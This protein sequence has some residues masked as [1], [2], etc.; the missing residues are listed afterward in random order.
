MRF[1]LNDVL[2]SIASPSTCNRRCR[3][4]L[5]LCPG[6]RSIARLGF[7]LDPLLE[8]L[9]GSKA[10]RLSA[11]TSRLQRIR[12]RT[13]SF[14][15]LR[16]GALTSPRRANS[17]E[18]ENGSAFIRRIAVKSFS[19]VLAFISGTMVWPIAIA[20]A[21]SIGGSSAFAEIVPGATCPPDFTCF[22]PE[23][24]DG[25]CRLPRL[26]SMQ[27]QRQLATRATDFREHMKKPASH[28]LIRRRFVE[29]V[30]SAET[31]PMA[32]QKST[33]TNRMRKRSLR[34][35]Q[36]VHA[37]RLFPRTQIRFLSM[38]DTTVKK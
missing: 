38:W 30:S 17:R 11:S 33:R 16:L 6:S 20:L 12:K 5:S 36:K 18:C 35:L 22:P 25:A 29:A 19:S 32:R 31:S 3:R 8:C 14:G 10:E 4:E 26:F 28:R 23:P 27:R 21:L 13:G 9:S 15:A 24:R 2:H 1:R 37:L 34:T 7:A